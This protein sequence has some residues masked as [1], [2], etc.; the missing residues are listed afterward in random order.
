ML[1]RGQYTYAACM[2]CISLY[3]DGMNVASLLEPNLILITDDSVYTNKQKE[4]RK[5]KA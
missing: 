3:H 5:K 4:K 1:V 2:T